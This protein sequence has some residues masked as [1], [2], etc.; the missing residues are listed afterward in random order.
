[1]INT[2]FKKIQIDKANRVM[3]LVMAGA[4]FLTIFALMS[5]YTLFNQLTYQGRVINA[6]QA[7]V[8]RLKQD[9]NIAQQLVSSYA[10]FVNQPRN[11]IGGNPSG[12]SPS[13]GD[14]AKIVL[15]ALPAQ[16][17]YPALTSSVQYL[18]D[19]AQLNIDSMSGTDQAATIASGSNNSTSSPTSSAITNSSS[20]SVPGTAVAMPFQF[21][22]DGPYANIQSLFSLFEK[23]IRPLPFQTLTIS[24]DQSDLKV[25]ATAQSYYQ[26]QKTFNITTETIK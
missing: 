10:S 5:S 20:S 19:Q 25:D 2:S 16:Y 13:S 3:V 23:S 18:L 4:S 11:L 6:K 21:S 7:A 15:D 9:S 12:N 24:G 26:P 14:N 1:M 17:D 22:A 8:N